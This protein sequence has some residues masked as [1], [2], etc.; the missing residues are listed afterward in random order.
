MNHILNIITDADRTEGSHLTD[1]QREQVIDELEM[2][3]VDA[4]RLEA[5]LSALNGVLGGKPKY[6]H[7]EFLDDQP[8]FDRV[9]EYGLAAL[10]NPALVRLALNP[11]TL[12]AL[13]EHVGE[14][15]FSDHWSKLFVRVGQEMIAARE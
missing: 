15:V 7:S 4:D 13:H 8:T 11:F 1:D 9:D 12:V 5:Y 3:L 6:N 10:E 14:D 2:C